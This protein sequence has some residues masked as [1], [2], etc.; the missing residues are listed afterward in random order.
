MKFIYIDKNGET[1]GPAD[2]V[3]VERAIAAGLI[4]RNSA[5]RNAM[6]GEFR[7]VGEFKCFEKALIAAGQA[8]GKDGEGEGGKKSA[9]GIWASLM[10]CSRKNSDVSSAF[11]REYL[12]KAAP[13]FTR[14]LAAFTDFI[15]LGI[16]G[17]VLLLLLPRTAGNVS[18][19]CTLM[20]IAAFFYYSI[21]L[22]V[23]AQTIG[24]YYWGIFLARK[25]LEEAYF[26]RCFFY[27][28]LWMITFPLL[29]ICFPFFK[30]NLAEL[31]TGTR[32]ICVYGAARA[33]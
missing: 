8:E 20:L 31:L 16:I 22:S 24:M 27:T 3:Q 6:L 4:D 5:L 28:Y 15:L 7:T 12:P 32:V 23:Y 11:S 14:L 26:L 25:D 2:Q 9:S 13:F 21:S 29:I 1:H 19:V 30:R 17:V 18:L 33:I 10:E